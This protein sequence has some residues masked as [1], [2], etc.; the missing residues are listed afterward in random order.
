M[1]GSV[2]KKVIFNECN[3]AGAD[4]SNCTFEDTVFSKCDLR[5]AIFYNGSLAG[6]DFRTSEL[7]GL[8]AFAPDLNGAI[9]E[10]RQAIE[11]A[12]Q[13]ADLLGLKLTND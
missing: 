2:F 10:R 13:L 12:E 4:F 11:L 6:T 8:K 1:C 3:F 7:L 5:N 9:I